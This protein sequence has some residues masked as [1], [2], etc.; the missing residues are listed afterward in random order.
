MAG[1]S[2]GME[3]RPVARD[4][5]PDQLRV[6]SQRVERGLAQGASTVG[7]GLA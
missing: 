2:P 4:L 6:L 5:A 7:C 3:R 1:R